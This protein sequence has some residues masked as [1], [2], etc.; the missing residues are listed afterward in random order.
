MRVQ[1]ARVLRVNRGG[2]ENF[3]RRN[4][5][6]ENRSLAQRHFGGFLVTGAAFQIE[7]SIYERS[8]I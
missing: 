3:A 4:A 7:V 8:R 2:D 5:L 1:R 6:E